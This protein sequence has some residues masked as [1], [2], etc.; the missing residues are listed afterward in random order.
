M[1]VRDASEQVRAAGANVVP[2][3]GNQDAI[4]VISDEEEDFEEYGADEDVLMGS[5]AG[6]S[7]AGL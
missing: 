6:E 5:P 1:D 2:K 7:D 3:F 4:S